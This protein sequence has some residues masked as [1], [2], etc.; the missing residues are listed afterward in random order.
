MSTDTETTTLPEAPRYWS[1]CQENM[2]RDDRG[3]WVSGTD[4]DRVVTD[5]L[6]R[7]EAAEKRESLAEARL[8]RIDRNQLS[9]GH[10]EVY[11]FTPDGKAVFCTLCR[12]EELQQHPPTALCR[13]YANA[14]PHGERCWRALD[15]RIGEMA[16]D[17]ADLQA[18]ELTD[19]AASKAADRIARLY[20]S[21]EFARAGGSSDW[22][23]LA[24]EA[25]I[26]ARGSR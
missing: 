11:A 21:G 9:C 6:A 22:K 8:E 26:A 24:L 25:I 15:S 12:I 2:S 5:L 10:F 16:K 1:P 20:N 7:L 3:G 19:K 14:W 23:V 13:I 4:H 17:I 18:R